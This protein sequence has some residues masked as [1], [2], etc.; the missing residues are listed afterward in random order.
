MVVLELFHLLLERLSNTQVVVERVYLQAREQQELLV[1][2]G[3]LG[4]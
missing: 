2:A 1:L 4:I 3:A